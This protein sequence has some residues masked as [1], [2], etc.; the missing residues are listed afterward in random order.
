MDIETILEMYEDDYNPSFTVPG[1]RNM[2][3]GGQLVS[4]SVDG[5]RPGYSGS[6]FTRALMLL[7]NLNRTGPIRNLEQ[8]LI[9]KNKSEGMDLLEAIKKAQAESTAIK[10]NAKNKILDDA[11]KETDI[12]SDDYVEL[13]DQKIKIIEPEY[14][15]DIKRWSNDRPDLADKTRALFYPDW[16]EAKY[17]ENYAGVLQDRQAKAIRENIDPNFKEP[18]S[19]SDQMV[20]DIDDMNTANIDE[21]FGRK[22]N[23]EGGFQQ[24]VQPNA[25]GSRPGYSGDNVRKLRSGEEVSN[26]K[27]KVFKYPRKNFLGKT[28]YY[29]TPQITRTNIEGIP[30]DVGTKLAR[31]QDGKQ[32]QVSTKG[33]NYLFKTE[34]QAVNFYNKNVKKGSGAQIK[35]TFDKQS[36]ELKKFFKDPKIYKRFYDGPLNVSSIDKIWLNISSAQKR[37]AKQLLETKD[38]NIKEA[39]K[40]TKQGYMRITDLADDLGR[41]TSLELIQSMKNSKKFNKLFPNYLEGLITASDNTKW[42]KTTPSTLTKLKQWANDPQSKGLADSTIKNIQTAYKDNK[43]M[44]YWKNWKPGTPID[45]KL[46]DSVHGKKGSAYTMMQLGRTLQGKEPIEGVKINKALG[47]KIIDAVRFK[48]KEFGEWHTA[49][50]RYAKQDMDTFLPPGK[51]GTT[52]TDYYNLLTKS[53][54]EVGLAEQ[55]FQIDEINALRSGVRGGTQP[56]SVFSQVLEGKYNMGIK[57][58]FDAENAKNQVKL[59][60]AL[61]MGDNETIKVSKKVLN[62]KQYIDYVIKLQNDQIDNFFTKVPE[63]KGKISLPKFDLRDPKTV[64][65]S[66]FDTFDKGVQ[67]AILK[68]F[69]KVGFT[70]DVGKKALT[71]KELLSKDLLK[72]AGT[73][74]KK[75]KGLLSYGGRVALAEGLSPEF[76]INE[77]KK[78]ARDLIAKNR[79]GTLAQKSIMRRITSG[80]TNFA[81]SILNPKE[82][83]D[84][85][86]Q[87]FSKGA[88]M[89]IPI[90][91]AVMAADDALRKDMDPK[92]AFAKTLTFG[93]IPSAA[94]FTDNVDIL[95]A[96]K[97]L[98][99]PNLSPAGK[100]YAQLIIDSANLNKGQSDTGIVES[101]KTLTEGPTNQFKNLQELKDKVSNASTSGRFDYENALAEMQ[102]T[103]KAKPKENK[104]FFDDAPDAPDVTPLTNKLATPAKSRGPMTEKKKQK[105]DLTPTTYQNYKPFSFTKEEFEDT[106]RQAGVLKEG[107]V[108]NDTFYKEQIETPMKA[109]QFKEYMELPSFRGTQE[110][111]SEGGIASLN[112]NKK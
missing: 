39:A 57:K 17:G 109:S 48:A 49:A 82:L 68:N 94:G 63:L 20:S 28:N 21:L 47:D 29:K 88:L 98:E 93:A 36:K 65:G 85:K 111:F 101:F 75:C 86:K 78:V 112:V 110:K 44:N 64:Y 40:L 30:N 66:R 3:A 12:T 69:K 7:K 79:E 70:V 104:F 54:R 92:E 60:E 61:A 16:A 46:I 96:K 103:F 72:L 102:G 90:F 62:K 33:K 9:R 22:K 97:M 76:C 84:I 52:F 87:L 1:P 107:Q 89:S 35:D 18:L 91:D 81:K 2:Y 53:L 24:L 25:D 73:A 34:K 42:I 6:A 95:N 51:S 56:Y 80:V 67:N 11:I 8:K 38:K 50:Y 71:Q 5:S 106:M 59:N 14:Y 83:F 19:S 55:G 99:N 15:D 37:Q 74:N 32:Y 100:E 13:I 105:V 23:A 43:L 27:T 31:L 41:T 108:Y 58:R 45:Q 10:N 26:K 4:P 77:G